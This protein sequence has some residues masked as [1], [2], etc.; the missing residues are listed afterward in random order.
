[1]KRW[2]SI[3]LIIVLFLNVFPH[4][5]DA[6]QKLTVTPKAV[7]VMASASKVVKATASGVKKPVYVWKSLNPK[8]AT[9]VNGKITGKSA[10]KTTVTVTVKG[11]K[12]K[13]NVAVTVTKRKYNATDLFKMANPSVALIEMLND[14]GQVVSSGSGFVVNK[15]EVVTNF[16]VLQGE[17]NVEAKVSF[18]NGSFIRTNV[19]KR[20]DET[21][22][23][24][25]LDISRIAPA[26]PILKMNGTR[27]ATGE[28]IYALGSPRGVS[29]TITEGMISNNSVVLDGF[30]YYQFNASTTYGNSGGPLLNIYGEV[31]G[32]VT[33]MFENSQNMNY[34]VPVRQLS[35]LDA[36][37]TAFIEEVQVPT[38]PIPVGKGD[39]YEEEPNGE[40][41]K[42]DLLRYADGYIHGTTSN[43]DDVDIYVFNVEKRTKLDFFGAFGDARISPYF[44]F[45][46]Y[47]LNEEPLAF[48]DPF[49]ST[50]GNGVTYQTLQ[51]TVEPGIYFLVVF[52][53]SGLSRTAYV[54]KD[55]LIMHKFQ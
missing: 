20:Y 10:G 52:P 29:N 50:S 32:V 6:S 1:M 44:A 24:A 15:G 35:L 25:V 16:H 37:R 48:S 34:A 8:V 30:E 17:E 53:V 51:T 7:T 19:I 2:L 3:A 23:L 27:V 39:T 21:L 40:W 46:I 36:R 18:A 13:Q 41:M 4:P 28:K 45:G 9:V 14:R 42:S 55:Y 49:V 43:L 26:P 22:D 47:D 12:L 31:V 54:N 38:L 33:W 5:V 11:T